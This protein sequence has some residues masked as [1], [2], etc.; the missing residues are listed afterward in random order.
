MTVNEEARSLLASLK[1][2]LEDLRESGVD[3]LPYAAAAVVTDRSPEM[4]K[5][6]AVAGGIRETL[7]EIRAGL[8]E[9]CR[10]GLGGIRTNLVFGVGDPHARIV[11]VGEAPGRDEDLQGE[12]FVG[13]AGQLLT[14]IIQAM[15]VERREVYICN[16]LKCRPPH[17]RNPLPAEIEQCHPFLLR[18]LKA[19]SPGAIVALGTFAAQTLLKTREPISKLRGKFHDYH[20]IPLMPTFHP[21]FLLRNASM[22]REVWEDMQQVMKLLGMEVPKKKID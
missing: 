6:A 11:F 12:P 20:G 14:K 7:D 13:E 5:V 17:N 22:K 10:C 3:G 16:V 1:V 2:Y 8:G 18:Q 15:G 21:A 9:C 19:I 4:N